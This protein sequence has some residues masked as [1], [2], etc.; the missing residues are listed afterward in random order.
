[1]R[2][3]TTSTQMSE[4]YEQELSLSLLVCQHLLYPS[5]QVV[6]VVMNTGD[7]DIAFKL[8]DIKDAGKQAVKVIALAH[9]IQ[10]F[11]YL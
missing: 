2:S 10:T 4:C 7:S 5:N 8:V 11:V 1:M 9:S 6:V 3:V